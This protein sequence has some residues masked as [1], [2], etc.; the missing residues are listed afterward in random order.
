MREQAVNLMGRVQ[1]YVEHTQNESREFQLYQFNWDRKKNQRKVALTPP[2]NYFII[3][4][5]F[6]CVCGFFLACAVLFSWLCHFFAHNFG[7][8]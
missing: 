4:F 6:L 5:S 8:I 7:W 3:K 1:K 2:E